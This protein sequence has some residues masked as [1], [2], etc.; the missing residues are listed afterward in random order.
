LKILKLTTSEANPVIAT[1]PNR[2]KDKM[3]FEIQHGSKGN[4]LWM[5]TANLA[6]QQFNPKDMA[7][8]IQLKDDNY[9]IKT[10]FKEGRPTEDKQG[11]VNYLITTDNMHNHKKDILL[12]WEI[13]NV[14][15]N[16]NIQYKIEGMVSELGIGYTGRERGSVIGKAPAPVLEII[17]D[18]VLSWSSEKDGT[19]ST[20]VI[21]YD[22]SKASW[23][24]GIIKRGPIGDTD[25]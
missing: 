2:S 5:W 3:Y 7:D 20:Q 24:I 16:A 4:T 9:F 12:L 19:L 18:C 21:K 22:Y 13:P 17:G 15:N 1:V 8:T 25:V 14:N 11:N 10:L 6:Y 23:D